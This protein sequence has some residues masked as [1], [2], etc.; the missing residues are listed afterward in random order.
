MAPR[1]ETSPRRV[2]VL[3]LHWHTL[4][5]DASIFSTC[6]CLALQANLIG[7]YVK[8]IE[9]HWNY[10]ITW[11]YVSNK[12]YKS[13]LVCFARWE[14][15]MRDLL[16]YKFAFV[17]LHQSWLEFCTLITKSRC[18][19]RQACTPLLESTIIK[20]IYELKKLISKGVQSHGS[21]S[22]RVW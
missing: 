3:S 15:W 21:P 14:I 9:T 10:V 2:Q 7:F 11:Y 6:P 16:V 13:S 1:S 19:L 5:A 17:L 12:N 4:D 18:K 8:S 20:S 22:V